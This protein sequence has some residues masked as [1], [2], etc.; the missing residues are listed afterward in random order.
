MVVT[1]SI[2]GCTNRKDR[3]SELE[4]YRLPTVITNQGEACEKLSNERR[5]V[6]LANIGQ[7]FKNKNLQNARVCSAHFVNGKLRNFALA[8]IKSFI[9]THKLDNLPDCTTI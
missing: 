8:C 4:F 3:E 6:W 5:R 7:D 1:C 9:Y 2:F